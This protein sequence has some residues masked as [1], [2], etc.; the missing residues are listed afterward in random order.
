ML[1][2]RC[3][4]VPTAASNV[5]T[6]LLNPVNTWADQ[7]AYNKTLAHLAQLFKKNFKKFEVGAWFLRST[8]VH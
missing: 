8:L 5:P 7:D 1:E 6:E 2:S 3:A 4:Q